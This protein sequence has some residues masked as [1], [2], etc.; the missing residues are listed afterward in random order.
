MTLATGYCVR[1][2]FSSLLKSIIV[3]QFRIIL[4]LAMMGVAWEIVATKAVQRESLGRVGY[5]HPRHR[6]PGTLSC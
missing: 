3:P 6:W 1:I 5:S 2:S 4:R